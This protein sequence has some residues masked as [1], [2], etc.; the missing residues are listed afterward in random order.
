MQ[1]ETTLDL[2]EGLPFEPMDDI[3]FEG[4][5]GSLISEAVDYQDNELSAVRSDL[6]DRYHGRFYGDESDGRSQ[7]RDRSIHTAVGQV[8]PALLRV[9][10]G[11]ERL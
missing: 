2:E 10:T 6:A 7:V 9:F 5:V 4:F 1:T 3:D 8:L 11:S